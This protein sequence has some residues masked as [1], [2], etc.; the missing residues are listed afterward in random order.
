MFNQKFKVMKN[1]MQKLVRT[2]LCLGVVSV[3]LIACDTDPANSNV[4]DL[5]QIDQVDN[6]VLEMDSTTVDS[7][8]VMDDNVDI[9]EDDAN[10]N[11]EME[12]VTEEQ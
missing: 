2:I 1:L 4:I 6:Q 3:S 7:N 9:T 5:D 10:N 12:D 8:D 11:V